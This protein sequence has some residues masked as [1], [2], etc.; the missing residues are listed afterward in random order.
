MLTRCDCSMAKQWSIKTN[1]EE[2]DRSW[3][4]TGSERLVT[5][6]GR[7]ETERVNLMLRDELWYCTQHWE[8]WEI[9]FLCSL[10]MWKPVHLLLTCI[11]IMVLLG[12]LRCVLPLAHITTDIASLSPFR[13]LVSMSFCVDFLSRLYRGHT[14]DQTSIEGGQLKYRLGKL[15]L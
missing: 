4:E 1:L 3:C 13:P 9:T 5:G 11:Y 6:S 12:C 10:A 7:R 8:S 14:M 2:R 15:I